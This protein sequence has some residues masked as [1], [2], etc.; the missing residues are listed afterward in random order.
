MTC[1][2][3]QKFLSGNALSYNSPLLGSG[4]FIFFPTMTCLI[5]DIVKETEPPALLSTPTPNPSGQG[6]FEK[7]FCTKKMQVRSNI[8][9][10]C[11]SWKLQGR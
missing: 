3:S 6:E 7:N 10:V 2:R 4:L 11:E 5:S 9:K 1:P 8:V